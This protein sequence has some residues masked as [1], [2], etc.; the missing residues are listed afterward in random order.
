[1]KYD[2][3]M[4]IWTGDSSAGSF[5]AVVWDN[6]NKAHHLSISSCSSCIVLLACFKAS[7]VETGLCLR[8]LIFYYANPNWTVQIHFSPVTSTQGSSP[9]TVTLPSIPCLP[10]QRESHTTRASA[11]SRMVMQLL[12]QNFSLAHI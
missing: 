4:I 11:V 5:H 12:E 8:V 1:M 6:D 2:S 10:T 9:K 7:P 3:D